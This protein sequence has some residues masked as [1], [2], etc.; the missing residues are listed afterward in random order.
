M[1]N[2]GSSELRIRLPVFEGPLDLLLYL[3]KK[4]ELDI[5]DIPIE[6][7]TRQYLDYLQFMKMLDLEVAG[8]FLVVA[9]TLVYIKSRTLLP[10]DL[11]PP[12]EDAEEDDP[13]WDLIRQLVEYKKFKDAAWQLHMK[14]LEQEKTY[15]RG[16]EVSVP[17]RAAGETIVGDLGIFDL[18]NAFQKVLARVNQ[19][20][21]LKE[22]FEER[23]TVGDK[24]NTIQQMMATRE[25]IFFEDLFIDVASRTEI[26]VTFLALLEL[27]RLKFL[28]VTQADPF[29]EIEIAHALDST[30]L[31]QKIVPGAE[32]ISAVY[33]SAP[34]S[35]SE[36]ERQPGPLAESHEVG[37]EDEIFEEPEETAEP[38]EAADVTDV[39][40]APEP[41]AEL[42][43]ETAAIES[44][45][46]E[47]PADETTE[48]A[49]EDATEETAETPET[50][51]VPV[52]EEIPDETPEEPIEEMVSEDTVPDDESAT[53]PTPDEPTEELP[54]EPEG[55]GEEPPAKDA[56]HP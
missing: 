45:T 19:S 1:E 16:A 7:I 30:P 9:A 23:F 47:S 32:N 29:A 26:V 34:A 31:F 14:Q 13:R 33:E 8:E 54:E 55:S 21:D 25:R 24:I 3:I 20:E 51:L 27:I 4:D 41:G 37:E 2:A 48:T 52:E 49:A 11:Q 22:I 17:E 40:D 5:Y 42:T 18:I 15:Q 35:T 43:E 36:P 50:I 38:S 6:R 56:S 12:E 53:E 10:K 39:T 44:E 28:R 46:P